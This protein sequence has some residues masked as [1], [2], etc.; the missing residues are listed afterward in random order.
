MYRNHIFFTFVFTAAC[1]GGLTARQKQSTDSSYP[2]TVDQQH[3][4]TD[5][6]KVD[7]VTYPGYP[8]RLRAKGV[9]AD[10]EVFVLI[11]ASGK[12]SQ[13]KIFHGSQYPELNEAATR[14]ALAQ[15]WIP[16]TRDGQPISSA[17][18]Y[19]YRF[20]LTD[21]P[22]CEPACIEQGHQ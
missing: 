6:Q 15:R 5:A 4:Y 3:L 14:A 18:K 13:A 22:A 9:E 1:G 7:P 19:S 21:D 11:D 10:V 16:A 8:S 2:H 17:K 12:V 20:R